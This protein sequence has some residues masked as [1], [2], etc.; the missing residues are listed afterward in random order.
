VI[1]LDELS[2]IRDILKRVEEKLDALGLELNK[3]LTPKRSDLKKLHG[4]FYRR[5]I[6]HA[7][8]KLELRFCPCCQRPTAEPDWHVDHWATYGG[9]ERTNGW[10]ICSS[11][12]YSLRAP[13]SII[14]QEHEDAFRSFHSLG[15]LL[16]KMDKH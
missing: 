8:A 14:R 15:D 12:N 1:M 2:E 7:Y 4:T 6:D 3:S 5:V 10:M 13:G 11:C 9:T 16:E